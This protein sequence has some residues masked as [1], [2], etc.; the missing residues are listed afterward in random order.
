MHGLLMGFFYNPYFAT[1]DVNGN[2]KI[3]NIPSGKYNVIDWYELSKKI[4]DF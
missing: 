2:Y 4:K 3:E 1:Q